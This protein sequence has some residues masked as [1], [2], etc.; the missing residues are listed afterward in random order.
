MIR[1]FWFLLLLA[2]LSIGAAVVADNPG[3][4]FL[5]W[6]G[7]KVDTSIGV[8]F[9]GVLLVSVSLAIIFRVWFIFRS[10]PR[11]LGKVRTI[12]RASCRERV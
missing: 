9:A 8:L 7:Y 4:V 5:E 3:V 11:R 1:A 10:A 12:G 6:L 2:L